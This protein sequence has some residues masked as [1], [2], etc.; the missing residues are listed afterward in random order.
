MD[1]S[2]DRPRFLERHGASAELDPLS[3]LEQADTRQALVSAIEALP[4]MK[5]AFSGTMDNLSTLDKQM[6]Q[7]VLKGKW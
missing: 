7:E 1:S 5:G 6:L 3:L 4:E 2:C